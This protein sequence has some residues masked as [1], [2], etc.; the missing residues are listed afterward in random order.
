MIDGT[1]P[2][3]AEGTARTDATS[4]PAGSSEPAS[5]TP[6]PAGPTPE[7]A[8]PSAGSAASG[9]AL[10]LVEG[11]A[12]G[13]PPRWLPGRIR[14]VLAGLLVVFAVVAGLAGI[15][16]L[17]RPAEASA[18]D[19]GTVP[20]AA[21]PSVQQDPDRPRATRT[22]DP[23]D[24]AT[25]LRPAQPGAPATIRIAGDTAPVVATGV[26]RDG[27]LEIPESP[28][29]VGWWTGSAVAG[30]PSDS[31]VLA[32]HVDSKTAGIGALAVLR[33]VELGTTVELTDVFRTTHRYK[34]VA[35]R[36]YDKHDL[37]A[38]EIFRVKGPARLVLITCGGP[39]DERTGSYQ[40]NVVVYAVPVR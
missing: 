36:T 32:G 11:R 37:P 4:A 23:G 16:V 27:E 17:G 3:G 5:P 2:A 29:V 31:T 38:D 10:R 20:V 26:R 12:A 9:P 30:S 34:V 1:G 33:T 40:D 13:P 19:L 7:P 24:A 18:P 35:R 22:E 39:F 21:Q 8:S 6:E 28:K 15:H 25:T 14:V